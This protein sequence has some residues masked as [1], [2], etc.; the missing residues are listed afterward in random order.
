MTTPDQPDAPSSPLVSRIQKIQTDHPWMDPAASVTL[1][2]SPT[3]DGVLSSIM[4]TLKQGVVNTWNGL[5]QWSHDPVLQ[6]KPT[7]STA[8]INYLTGTVGPLPVADHDLLHIQGELQKRGFGAGLAI[9]GVW[10]AGWNGA[11]S[12]YTQAHVQSQLAGNRPG[13][14]SSHGLLHGALDS[15]SPSG[16]ADAVWGTIKSIPGDLQQLGTDIGGTFSQ[17]W[18]GIK[19]IP[20]TISHPGQLFEQGG[21][22]SEAQ[23]HDRATGQRVANNALGGNLTQAQ[24]EATAGTSADLLN[25]INNVGTLFLLSGIGSAAKGVTS[26]AQQEARRGLLTR[27]TTQEAVRGP[28]VVARTLL[29]RPG[30]RF[31]GGAAAGSVAGGVQAEATGSD[32]GSGVAGGALLGAGAGLAGPRI[33]RRAAQV[34]GKDEGFAFPSHAVTNLPV[35]G[36]VGPVLGKLLPEVG[37]D[38][39]IVEGGAPGA[40]YALRTKLATPYQFGAVRLL[41]G[42]ASE[43]Q[44]FSLKAHAVGYLE[45]QFGPN[46]GLIQH[47]MD[48]SHPLDTVNASLRAA[49]SQITGGAFKADLDSLVYLMGR[50]TT[51]AVLKRDVTAVHDEFVQ[52]MVDNGLMRQFENGSGKNYKELLADFDNDPALLHTFLQQKVYET[53]AWHAAERSVANAS[54][55]APDLMEQAGVT[56]G[57][58]EWYQMHRAEAAAV[59]NDPASL[60]AAVKELAAPNHQY[61]TDA[62]RQQMTA[63]LG[64]GEAFK[65]NTG[66]AYVRAGNEVRQLLDMP[67]IGD[68][69]RTPQ[70]LAF[71]SNVDRNL[72]LAERAATLTTGDINPGVLGL[73]RKGGMSKQDGLRRLK[74][75]IS[76]HDADMMRDGTPS[77]DWFEQIYSDLH[78][79]FNLDDRRLRV[80][81]QNPEKL[82]DLYRDHVNQLAAEVFPHPDA[83]KSVTDMISRIEREGY[84]LVAGEDIGHGFRPDLPTLQDFGAA[85]TRLRTVTDRLG[86]G[87]DLVSR[88]SMAIDRSY[89]I[90]KN[91]AQDLFESGKY[92]LPP[93]AT[94]QTIVRMLRDPDALPK[95]LG[96]VRNALMDLFARAHKATTDAL[97]ETGQAD[98]ADHALAILKQQ[99]AVNGGLARFSL[100]DFK[101][102]LTQKVTVGEDGIL[103][104]A[105]EGAAEAQPYLTDDAATAVYKAVHR[106]YAQTPV[107]M[108]GAGKIE[109]FVKYLPFKL[110]D[111]AAPNSHIA[112]TVANL[113]TSLARV[114][115]ELR[116]NLSPLFDARRVFKTNVKMMVDGVQGTMTPVKHLREMGQWEDA[117]ALL[118]TLQGSKGRFTS[119]DDADSW[120]DAHGV[121]G[122]YNP[123]HYE[124]YYAFMKKQQGATDQEIKDGLVRVFQYGRDGMEGRTAMERSMNTVFFPFS[125]EKTVM[126]NV[127]SYLLDRPAQM[128][129]ISNSLDA[130]RDF[131]NHHKDNPLAQQWIE[132]HLPLLKEAERLNTFATGFSLGEPG[133]VNRPILNAFLPQSWDTSKDRTALLGRFIPA[134]T[135][136]QRIINEGTD[137]QRIVRTALS[138]GMRTLHGDDGVGILNSQPVAETANQQVHDALNLKAQLLVTFGPVLAYNL[139]KPLDQQYTFGA[140]PGIPADYRNA[141]IT[142]SNLAEII[143]LR[144]PEWDPT[145]G[146]Q[147]ATANKRNFD[148][149]VRKLQSAGD[150]RA[151]AYEDF[152]TKANTAIGHINHDQYPPEQEAQVQDLFRQRAM[153]FAKT[154]PAFLKIYN[155][156]FR[157][158]FGP[159][160]RIS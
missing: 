126:R 1:A 29:S 90:Q 40:Y 108:I 47:A 88:R 58:W 60:D 46:A 18:G 78:N 116:F 127:G 96:P 158:A 156:M 157:N 136:L 19:S 6:D 160:E 65:A 128:L 146:A 56:P 49:T 82:L 149:L 9:N 144:Y 141:P 123:R 35:V 137:Q 110:A 148:I 92:T 23:T 79:H 55:N 48:S 32:L 71:Q 37:A 86:L 54:H 109:A 98:N 151:T 57:S 30:K 24:A 99:L 93:Y 77:R 122:L 73:M 69:L 62:M 129:I 52:G 81:D 154:D 8:F 26:L 12:D 45:Q 85:T 89:R 111:K 25:Q 147:I 83:P 75:I 138:N 142:R 80:F 50:G 139:N 64:T 133:G 104:P 84:R 34:A 76:Q 43:A 102:I 51:S 143:H 103:R 68:H 106:A 124:A 33:L 66:A 97:V 44:A 28:G 101:K 134:I 105:E 114:R 87:T 4:D 95:T 39:R 67:N 153:E 7:A 42:A 22:H 121:F 118:D 125:F 72:P 10:N 130:Y 107:N 31:I 155:K 159:I 3:S 100:T 91:I 36:R 14:A 145:K 38:G 53:A 140:G 5:T 150:A 152:Y 132:T 115:D 41:S 117:H 16:I 15:I 74:D 21:K 70:N 120:L 17:A 11:F 113:P 63:N 112:T 59:F 94:P 2:S 131:S 20:D 13:H 61:L 27:L 135:D 119:L